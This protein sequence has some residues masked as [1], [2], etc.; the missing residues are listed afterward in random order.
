MSISARRRAAAAALATCALLSC[1]GIACAQVAPDVSAFRWH[2]SG[3]RDH[4]LTGKVWSAKAA[5]LVQVQAL[6][7]ELWGTHFVLLGEVHDNAD[8]HAWQGWIISRIKSLRQQ[9]ARPPPFA[10]VVFE[11]IRTDQLGALARFE[12]LHR[13][14]QRPATTHDLFQL[15]EW[16][17]SGWPSEDKF[18]GLFQSVLQGVAIYPANPPREQVRTVARGGMA[19]LSADDRARIKLDT[20]L[21]PALADDLTAELKGSHCGMLPDAAIP[22][23]SIAQRYRDAAFADAMLTAADKHGA[24]ILVAGN[25][26]VRTDRGVPW[27]LR[28]RAP[29]RR[30]ASVMMLEVEDGQTDPAAYVPRDPDGR[31]A[32]DFIMFTPRAE[33]PD[34]CASMR[35]GADKKG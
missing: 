14:A 29:D 7:S 17:K 31:P 2:E 9:P 15:L 18:Q 33:R 32:V 22:A 28:Q 4:P 24:A 5:G 23:M 13:E 6:E 34:P 11:H 1:A 8:A 20:P 19:A 35:Q 25:G 30:V 3:L 16:S 12:E 26:H 27:Y 10:A 21:D